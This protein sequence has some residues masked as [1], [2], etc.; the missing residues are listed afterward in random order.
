MSQWRS[1]HFFASEINRVIPPS[2]VKHWAFKVFHS[3]EGNL[4]EV[5]SFESASVELDQKLTSLGNEMPPTA[6][7]KTC[8]CRLYFKLVLRSCKCIVHICKL[9]SHPAPP[10]STEV[11][12]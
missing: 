11:W 1:H 5:V 12:M 2:R 6:D 10:H 7:T 9:L 4:R 8:A 3:G